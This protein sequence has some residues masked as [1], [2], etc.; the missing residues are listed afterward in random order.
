MENDYDIFLN[1]DA[2]FS[3]PTRYLRGL[4]AGMQT[5][6]VMI[7]FALHPRRRHAG[8]A[9]VARV[10]E[11]QHQLV[12]GAALRMPARTRA[13]ASAVP[14]RERYGPPTRA[15]PFARLL[16]SAGKCLFRCFQAGGGASIGRTADCVRG[17]R[18]AER[19]W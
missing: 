5:A 7:G 6:D 1:L 15:R 16:V 8:L 17:N 14:R 12:R 10:H 2:D 19:R 18:K 9:A 3:H 4:V 11:P 13:A